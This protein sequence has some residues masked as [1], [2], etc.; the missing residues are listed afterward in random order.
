MNY[1]DI[2]NSQFACMFSNLKT[3]ATKSAKKET[4]VRKLFPQGPPF[5]CTCI[6]ETG[7]I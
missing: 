1:S 3:L 5:P 7:E 4:L 2:S 6:P